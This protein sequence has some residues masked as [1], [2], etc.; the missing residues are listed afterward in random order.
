MSDTDRRHSS[1]NRRFGPTLRRRVRAALGYPPP[2]V[3]GPLVAMAMRSERAAFACPVDRLSLPIGLRFSSWNPFVHAA[4]DIAASAEAGYDGSVLE[5]YYQ[6]VQPRHAAEALLGFEDAP[7]VLA[8]HRPIAA[9]CTP[10]ERL[11]PERMVPKVAEWVRADYLEHGVEDLDLAAGFKY[12]GPTH[13]RVGEVEFER[14]RRL[15]ESLRR[16]GFLRRHGDVLVEVVRRGDEFL[17]LNSGGGAHRSA[18]AAAIGLHT[19]PARPVRNL[20]DRD[21]AE[22]WPN[23]RSGLW[24]IRQARR[25]VD[26]LFDFDYL[27]WASGLGLGDDLGGARDES[28]PAA[29]AAP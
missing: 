7:G 14:L 16:R 20:I 28:T 25:Y 11:G 9:F 13:H 3:E 26:H 10:W 17:F 5:R 8:G 6:A 2:V 22:D 1:I 27:A 21:R 18:V 15:V 19:V 24:T 23:V 29:R 12:F 4:R